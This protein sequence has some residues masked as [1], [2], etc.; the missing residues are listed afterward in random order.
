MSLTDSHAL[1]NGLT[2][3]HFHYSAQPLI[4]ISIIILRRRVR[5]LGGCHVL[6]SVTLRLLLETLEPGFDADRRGHARGLIDAVGAIKCAR[7]VYGTDG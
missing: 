7:T 5:S 2:V 1:M 6:Y 4:T 3:S